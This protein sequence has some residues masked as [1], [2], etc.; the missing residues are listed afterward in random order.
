MPGTA[1]FPG[2][3]A[4]F[5]KPIAT[6]LIVTAL[7]ALNVVIASGPASA[8]V[9]C[10]FGAPSHIV[11]IMSTDTQLRIVRDGATI[12][13]Q[14]SSGPPGACGTVTTEDRVEIDLGS[15]SFARLTLDLSGGLFEP[16]VDE[17]SSSSREIE[18]QVSNLGPSTVV[19]VKGS[20]GGDS[21]SFGDRF[22]LPDFRTVTDVNLNGFADGD[23]PDGD[24]VIDGRPVDL[25]AFGNGGDDVL[26]G[27]GLGTAN[28]HV[29][30]VR[31][32]LTDGPGADSVTGGHNADQIEPEVGDAGDSFAG[33]DGDDFINYE[34]AS[35]GVSVSLDNHPNDGVACPGLGCEGDNVHSDFESVRATPFNDDLVGSAGPNSLDPGPGTNTLSGRGGDDQLVDRGGK[36]I[37]SGGPGFDSVTYFGEDADVTVTLDDVANDGPGGA[38]DNVRSDVEAVQGGHGDDHLVGNDKANLLQ[39]ATG[40]DVL[41][42]RG[43]NDILGRDL[44]PGSDEFIGGLGMDLVDYFFFGGDLTL[45]IDGVANDRVIG[46]PGQGVDN[47]H[48]DVENV[49]GGLG[50]DRITGSAGSNRLA[51]GP[52]EDTLVGQ[53]GNDTLLGGAD[54]DTLTGGPGLDTASFADATAGVAADLLTGTANGDGSDSLNG[55][56]RLSGSPFGDHLVGTLGPNRLSG[57]AGAD[58]LKGLAGNDVLLGGRGNDTLDGGQDSDAC[59]QGPGSGS[60]THCEH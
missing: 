8:T 29:T 30:G 26:T 42:G 49:S 6:G 48:A 59:K 13:V 60:V 52:G 22:V 51:G 44:S 33:G 5:A 47:I 53:G 17:P 4:R 25:A 57:G 28:T 38:H 7:I 43:G 36:D 46:D 23:T 16:G 9:S 11:S 20:D 39:G 12:A 32:T 55:L 58:D 40:D 35:T 56:E 24:V 31:L 19:L 21:V 15:T 14:G 1:G 3:A 10:G 37:F 34:A 54:D 45:S 27:A 41:E 50:D 18:F 2:R